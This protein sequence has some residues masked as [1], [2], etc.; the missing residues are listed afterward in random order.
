MNSLQQSNITYRNTN[1]TI[2]SINNTFYLKDKTI[3]YF[4]G[5]YTCHVGNETISLPI[6]PHFIIV[7]AQKAGTTAI[8]EILT[9]SVPNFLRTT[10]FEG[11]YWDQIVNIEMAKRISSDQHCKSLRWYF[12]KWKSAL[13]KPNTILFEKTPRYLPMRGIPKVIDYIVH[14][15][16]KLLSFFGILLIVCIHITKWL[17]NV[18][19]IVLAHLKMN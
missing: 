6:F 1:A 19:L 7:G 15:S 3:H 17:S 4:N 16:Q 5:S 11:H 13:V 10:R 9:R 2:S 12:A 8:S 14:I 18:T